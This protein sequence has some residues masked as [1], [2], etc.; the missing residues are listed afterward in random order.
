MPH[1]LINLATQLQRKEISSVE[2]TTEYLNKIKKQNKKTNSYIFTNEEVSL[3]QA[4]KADEI[5]K[6]GSP[7]VLTG[8]PMSLKDNIMTIDMPTT[9]A[10]KMLAKY[11]PSY[12]ATVYTKLLNNGAV[13]LGKTNLDEFAMGS[14]TLNGYFGETSNPYDTDKIAGGSSGGSAA[15]V[16]EDTSI[17]SLGS[18]TG[19][20]IRQPASYCGVV[21]FKPTYGAVSRN[22]L[23]ALASSF[24]QI[25]PIAKNVEDARIVFNV[26]KGKD[27][28][29]M[30]AFEIPRTTRQNPVIGIDEDSIQ[31]IA[32]KDT[33]KVFEKAINACKKLGYKTVKI[34]S[35]Y[36]DLYIKLYF[37]LAYAE[38]ASNMGRYTGIGFG[39]HTKSSYIDTDDFIRKTRSEAFGD[40]VKTRV[41]FGNYMLSGDNMKKYYYK[42]LKIRHDLIE[43]YYLNIFNKCDFILSPTTPT[44]A[45]RKDHKYSSVEEGSLPNIFALPANLIGLPS[46]T[47]PFG[48]SSENMPI[49]IMLSGKKNF[50][51]ALFTVAKNFEQYS[52]HK[53]LDIK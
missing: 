9:A 23:I 27:E 16:A 31:K 42:A 29:D 34:N 49:G 53:S 7:S 43:D 15:S 18:D 44:A 4:K 46:I 10:S 13:L 19:G 39:Y 48:M 30:T 37:V 47:I 25:G 36:D 41:M 1:S 22:G 26:I 32:D 50:D 24:D 14:S 45:P 35:K 33:L 51:N 28:F 11:I 12:S 40:D 52:E 6:K 38:M 17:Y 8:I 21:G 3:N 5:I 2:L 20:S